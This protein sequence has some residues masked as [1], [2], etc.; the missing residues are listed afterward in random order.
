[1]NQ[2]E[3]NQLYGRM[4][5]ACDIELAIESGQFQTLGDV[6]AALKARSSHIEG[7]LQAAG[8]FPAPRYAI[9]RDE[10]G[11]PIVVPLQ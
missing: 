11:E 2:D 8:L 6:L 1:M 9:L 10:T 7:Q 4:M 5:E 3:A